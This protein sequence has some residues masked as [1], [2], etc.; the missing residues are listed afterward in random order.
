MRSTPFHICATRM[1]L[2]LAAVVGASLPGPSLGQPYPV[3]PIRLV[4][5]SS[6]GGGIDAL[7]RI[8]ANSP[9]GLGQ[10]IVVENRGGA[11]GIIGTEIVAK[12][13]PDG[14]TLLLGFT[15][16][17][18]VNPGLYPKLPYDPVRDLAPITQVSASPPLIVVHPS[19]PARSLKELVKLDRARPGQ[20][21][22]GTGGIGT[23][24]HLTMEMFNLAAGTRVLHVPYKGVGPALSDVIA[25][26]ITL[27]VSS[28]ISS[29]PHVQAGR[30]RGLAVA[31]RKR[32]AVLPDV[33]TVIESGWPGFESTSWFGVL[34][35]A[36]TPPAVVAR[37]HKEITGQLRRPEVRE[38]IT[39]T[40][41][42]VVGDTPE[43]F[44]AYIKTEIVKWAKVVK[45]ANIKVD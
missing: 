32:Q 38:Q 40:S 30:L 43:E 42:D 10:P 3:K 20:L 2:S 36:G 21:T 24:G 37:L 22:Y 29:A 35:P 4:A 28:P 14:Y 26:Q 23:G 31:G 18:A 41:A 27:M 12:A 34:A 6:T 44:A 15:G 8:I 7:A 33:P 16:A 11:N 5:P 39:R 13:A 19:V 17:I 25:G 45:A 9:H 1:L